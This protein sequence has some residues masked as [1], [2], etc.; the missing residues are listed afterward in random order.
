MIHDKIHKDAV[1]IRAAYDVDKSTMIESDTEEL[2]MNTVP[3]FRVAATDL[4]P[5]KSV[6]HHVAR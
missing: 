1:I 4:H 2:E 5:L 3:C 6:Q